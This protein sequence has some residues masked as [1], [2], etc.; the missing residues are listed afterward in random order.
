[1]ARKAFEEVRLA[2]REAK[3]ITLSGKDLARCK[4][5][6][7]AEGNMLADQKRTKP[8]RQN[9][10]IYIEKL[11]S[12]RRFAHGTMDNSERVSAFVD[13]C[14]EC[15]KDKKLPESSSVIENL[16]KE[17]AKLKQTTKQIALKIVNS[18]SLTQRFIDMSKTCDDL[19]NKLSLYEDFIRSLGYD[20]FALPDT[21][22]YQAQPSERFLFLEA[23]GN[24]VDTSSG[25]VI[26]GERKQEIEKEL[27]Q[28][29]SNDIDEQ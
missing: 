16:R 14:I 15:R 19:T 6:Y 12:D 27:E 5:V 10:G 17:N 26:T 29:D 21:A 2:F 7:E 4:A 22:D 1:M 25:E 11:P 13:Y 24:W 20:P 9:Y 23:T 18:D 8:T 28:N 3:G